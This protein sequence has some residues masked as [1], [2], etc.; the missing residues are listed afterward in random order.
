L[1]VTFSVNDN[2]DART[3]TFSVHLNNVA[4]TVTLTGAQSVN[5]GTTYTY[6]YAVSDPGSETF[7]RD[8]Q[9][10]GAGGTLSN[11]NLNPATGAG[12]F[13]CNWDD[14]PASKSASVTVSDGDGGSDS[15]SL[16]V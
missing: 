4:P 16:A 6:S 11:G 14:G 15:K 3:N 10:C 12:S 1:P 13:D 2:S 8:A 5:E 9:S 7:S